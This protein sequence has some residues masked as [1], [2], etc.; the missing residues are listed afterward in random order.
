MNLYQSY[1]VSTLHEV[2]FPACNN[3]TTIEDAVDSLRSIVYLGDIPQTPVRLKTSLYGCSAA[4]V[5][6]AA[7]HHRASSTYSTPLTYPSLES[8]A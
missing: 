6:D 3:P 7:P 5:P 2:D 8:P 1:E 4:L